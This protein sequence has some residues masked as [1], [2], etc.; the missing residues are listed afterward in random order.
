MD[1]PGTHR[2]WAGGPAQGISAALLSAVVLGLAPIFGK[3]A[4]LAG[5]PPLSVVALRTIAAAAGLWLILGLTRRK[6]LYIYPLGLLGCLAAGLINGLGSLMYYSGLGRLDASLAQLLYTLYPVVLTAFARLQGHRISGLTLFRMALALA[7][8]FLLT[9][10][11]GSAAD[12]VGAGLMLGAGVMYAAHLVIS[13]RVLYDVP[14]P[15][16]ALYILTA[17][18]VTVSVGYGL[19]GAP[20]L[21]PTAGAWQAVALL[22]LVTVVSRLA[23]FMGVKRLGGVQAALI[24]LSELLVTVLCAL[25]LLGES[26]SRLQWLG[27][28]LLTASVL[29]VTRE[30]RL[31]PPPA[32]PWTALLK[33]EAGE[34]E[35]PGKRPETGDPERPRDSGIP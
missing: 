20:A 29:L 10:P 5:T 3:Q 16:V 12:W 14:A 26:L 30:R 4:I 17:M 28:A 19:A 34:L 8:V 15:T 35:Q 23:L 11:G 25:L 1:T 9:H 21:P 24:G 32:Q 2:R 31:D 27:A 22:T 7:A 18:A 6:Y 13:Q 33:L